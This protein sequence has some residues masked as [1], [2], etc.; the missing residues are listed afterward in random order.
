MSVVVFVNINIY[1][2]FQLPSFTG[3]KVMM[4]PQNLNNGSH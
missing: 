1:I 3:S 4:T 2:K